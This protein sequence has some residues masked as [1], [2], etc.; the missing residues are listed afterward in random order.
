[1]R[2][3][4]C[5]VLFQPKAFADHV[6]N[7][8]ACRPTISLD[9][10]KK[11]R[12]ENAKVN[13]RESLAPLS[14][15]YVSQVSLAKTD[16]TIKFQI[17]GYQEDGSGSYTISR[18][19]RQLLGLLGVIM[20]KESENPIAQAARKVHHLL[21]ESCVL[22]EKHTT[23]GDNMLEMSIQHFVN[24]LLRDIRLK[25]MQEVRAFLEIHKK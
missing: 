8:Q 21:I 1:V 5:F 16:Q 17:Q 13:L 2:C 12:A 11:L 19:T 24:D 4:S 20:K 22:R 9:E 25:N 14:N 15:L 6:Q 7:N 18:G 10:F 3:A 23:E